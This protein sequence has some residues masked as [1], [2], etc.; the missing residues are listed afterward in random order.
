MLLCSTQKFINITTRPSEYM[1]TCCNPHLG[2]LQAN[3]SHKI[4]YNCM[5]NRLRS[6][7]GT[8][9]EKKPLSANC[10]KSEIPTMELF[11]QCTDLPHI[12]IKFTPR[13]SYEAGPK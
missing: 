2:H 12:L 6:Q 5:L 4:N 9:L 10:S 3:I 11:Q 7:T 8:S 13:Y 1:A